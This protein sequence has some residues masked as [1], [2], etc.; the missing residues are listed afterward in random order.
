MFI[1]LSC[2]N[3]F[4][5]L[6]TSENRKGQKIMMVKPEEVGM[7]SQ[8]LERI[9]MHLDKRYIEAGRVSGTLIL[10][11]RMGKIVYF[12][13]QGH[14]EFERRR[15]LQQDSIFR[16]YSMTK[17][18]TSVALMMLYEQGEF[19]L[20][21]PVHTYIPS[22]EN[23]QVFVTGN[24]PLWV[25][26]PAIRPMTIRD[27]LSHCSGLTYG[28]MERSNVDAAYRMLGIADRTKPGYTLKDMIEALSD[29][30]LEFSP[31]TR[32]N[33]SVATD[34]VGYL[35]ELLSGRRFDAYIDEEILKPLGM[36]DTGFT[37]KDSQLPRFACNYELQPE[38]AVTLI[39]SP[40]S[41]QYRECSFFSGGG[42][43]VST[44]G[45]YLRFLMMLRNGGELDGVRLISRKTID[46]MTRNHLPDGRDLTQLA[47]PGRFAETP[48]AGNGF[49]LGF[50]IMLD[51][52][53]AQIVGT[54]GEYNW[55]GMA[56]TAF[57]VDP[58]EDM[59][60][61]FMTQLV[62]S[63]AYPVRRELRTLTY[64]ALID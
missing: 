14:L 11:A 5:L 49:G 53:R 3:I 40:E 58:T 37:I 12:E 23:Q 41:S 8:R 28:F 27:L 10:V 13:P 35:V 36:T 25:T 19:Q 60:V 52:G 31:G 39:D 16:I 45:D 7:S 48:Y 2:L 43:L 46:L 18:I 24:H 42:G 34:V 6:S 63:S 21:D 57:W 26:T 51:P 62:P 44:A 54:P 61:I 47:L 20:D 50:S 17:P 4:A 55:G 15:S 29:I 56:S 59:I 38:G 1:L 64:S 9:R 32:W 30:P 22:W 33:Y